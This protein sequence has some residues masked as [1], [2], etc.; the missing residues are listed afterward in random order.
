MVTG[1]W[2]PNDCVYL[3][4]KD[5]GPHKTQGEAV[6]SIHN[7]MGTNIFQVDPLFFEELEGFVNILQAVDPHTTPCGP[8]LGENSG[9][10]YYFC[11]K[12]LYY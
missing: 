7:V 8:R 11:Y 4:A 1:L 9:I 5:D 6:V 3:E 2:L 10:Y 12:S